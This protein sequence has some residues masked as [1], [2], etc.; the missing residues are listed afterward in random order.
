M[1]VPLPH[2]AQDERGFILV[3]VVTFMLALTILGMSL[4]A[5]SSYEAQFFTASAAREQSLQNSESGMEVVKALIG[6]AG[7]QLEDAHHAEGQL[8]IT[9]AMAYQQRSAL[10]T[11]TT[12]TGPVDWESPYGV[13][14]VV[15]AR[16]GG[17]ERTLQAKFVPGG[18]DNP[19]QRLLCAGRGIVINSENGTN[20]TLQLSGRVWHPVQ[21]AA[22]TAWTNL[23]D[24]NSGGPVQRGTPPFPDAKSLVDANL[25][26]APEVSHDFTNSSN[27]TMTFNGSAGGRF[28]SSPSGLNRPTAADEDKAPEF[29]AYT[30]YTGADLNITVGGVAVW[31][32]PAGVCFKDQVIVKLLSGN[33]SGTLVI[34]S[35]PSGRDADDPNRGITFKGGLQVESNVQVFLVSNGDISLIHHNDDTQHDARSIS[36]VAGGRIELGGPSSGDFKLTYDASS[37][38]AL[39]DQLLAVNKL[40]RVLGGS[41]STFVA[42]RGSWLETTPR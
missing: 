26:L 21:S 24:W 8:G 41:S 31:L 7:A 1:R 35:E 40:P 13:V 2:P 17:V 42:D 20:E 27:Y 23:V 28:F 25:G 22:D 38:D 6:T 16:A 36:I 9:H 32:V 37:M 14:I 5:L 29:N 10:V 11:D 34:V 18:V 30:F 39:A 3:G 15:A 4:F 19:Y 33:S 12:S